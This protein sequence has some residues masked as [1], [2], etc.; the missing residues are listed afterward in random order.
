MK[1]CPVGAELFHADRGTDMKDNSRFLAIL[2][3][4]LTTSAS[5]PHCSPTQLQKSLKALNKSYS[6]HYCTLSA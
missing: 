2:R 6:M 5:H 1:I 3:T 4:G